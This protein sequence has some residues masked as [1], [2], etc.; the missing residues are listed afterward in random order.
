MRTLAAAVLALL[1][2]V[3][4]AEAQFVVRLFSTGPTLPATC[5][6]ADGFL[7]TG[8]SACVYVCVGGA[9]VAVETPPAWGEIGGTLSS[10]ADLQTSLN[11][12][13]ATLVSGTTIKTI[14]GASVLGSGNLVVTGSGA[15]WGDITGTLAD[16]TDL[17][18][19]LD[20]K[21]AAGSYAT[22]AEGAL[23]LT[24]L[25]P[26]G[27]GSL[28][29]GLTKSQVGLGNVDNT[30]DSAK[31]VASAA[32][33]TTPRTING[34]SFNGTANITVPAA[35]STLTDNVPVGKLNSGTGASSSTYWRG[36]GTWATPPGGSS[37]TVLT[38]GG[39]VSTAANTT[40]V[41]I[42]G[43]S[44]SATAATR[45]KIEIWSIHQSAA[46][47][48]GYGIGVN[49]TSA[50]QLVALTG[51]SQLAN[52]GTVSAWSAIANNAIVGV[53]SGVPSNATNVPSHGGG[54][55]LANASTTNTCQFLL[56]SETTA[57][58][59]IKAGSV[60]IV[61]ALS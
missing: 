29:T 46:A 31:S 34:V 32:A 27:N 39:D 43:I 12:K 59:T 33:L 60:F 10:Q 28:L 30:A 54:Q 2:L 4:P 19:A 49:C 7:L 11:A 8:A 42:T 55:I 40:P 53:T 3:A 16:Q 26:A 17:Q 38:L 61:R 45:Y 52:T 44:F 5:R 36:D 25:Q 41:N 22:A 6:A 18:A 47:A 35:G 1:A 13:Q 58:T 51:Y 20:G 37:D 14:N 57:V 24:A 56:R 9:W 21:Q 15:A 50:P 48:T 23:A